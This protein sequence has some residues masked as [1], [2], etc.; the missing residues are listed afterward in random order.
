MTLI[1]Y[2][3]TAGLFILALNLFSANIN[4]QIYVEGVDYTKV[5]GI[6]ESSPAVVREFFHTIVP[7][8]TAKIRFL[9]K[10]LLYS[11]GK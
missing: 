10:Q 9:S 11:R 5:V 2:Q 8:V 6:P 3:L 4:A 1:K 7:I